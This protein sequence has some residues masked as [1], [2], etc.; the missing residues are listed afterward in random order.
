[1]NSGARI[2]QGF[3]HRWAQMKH[4]FIPS[5]K[6]WVYPRL[7]LILAFRIEKLAGAVIIRFRHEDAGGPV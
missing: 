2:Q 6:T 7:K 5:V 3:G 1:M 4:K